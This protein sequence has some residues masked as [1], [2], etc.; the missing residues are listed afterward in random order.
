MLTL[1]DV[2]RIQTVNEA[3]S[4]SESRVVTTTRE[5][6][7]DECRKYMISNLPPEYTDGSWS[8]ERRANELTKIITDYVERHQIAVEGFVDAD[9]NIDTGALLD[10]TLDNMRGEGILKAALED[11]DIDEIQVN[12]KDTIFV[13]RK[14]VPEPYTVKGVSQRFTNDKEIAI[15]LNKLC[16]DGTGNIPQFSPGAPLLNAKTAAKQYRVNAVHNTAN[17]RGLPPYDGPITTIV[18]RKFKE[19]KLNFDD[20][21][22]GGSVTP[23]MARLLSLI[24]RINMNTFFIGPTASGK[25]TLLTAVAQNIPISKRLCLVQNPTEITFFERDAAGVNKRNVLHWEANDGANADKKNTATMSNLISNALRVTPEVLILGE[26]R[27]P[28]EFTQLQRAMQTGHRVIGTYHAKDA[29]DAIERGAS[30]LSTGMGVSL[31]EAK[32]QWARSVDIIITQFKFPDGSRKVMEITEV[33]GTDADGEVKLSPIIEYQLVRSYIDPETGKEKIDGKFEFVNPI[34][35]KF[36][37]ALIKDGVPE[38]RF[39]EF[40]S[41]TGGAIN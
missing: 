17:A 25:T 3:A 13:V 41:T 2:Y 12:D 15:L 21:V 1:H 11:P 5:K 27:A 9:G 6:Y 4:S 20:M 31:S 33:I 40:L 18:I 36:K 22:R 14:G 38:E 32:K 30:E 39:R 35:E 24:G 29:A 28:D 26:A 19:T 7:F 37:Q 23:K 10:A 34:S 8:A 16:D